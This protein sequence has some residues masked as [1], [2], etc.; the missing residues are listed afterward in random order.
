M[1]PLAGC[2]LVLCGLVALAILAADVPGT[3]AVRRQTRS[4]DCLKQFADG[5][6][7]TQIRCGY[8]PVPPGRSTAGRDCKH[9]SALLMA[10]LADGALP[11][12]RTCDAH[13]RPFEIVGSG[14]VDGAHSAIPGNCIARY[15][16]DWTSEIL[17]ASYGSDGKPNG[18]AGYYERGPLSADVVLRGQVA[19]GG[20]ISVWRAN[21]E[22]IAPNQLGSA[23]ANLLFGP[24]QD[25]RCRCE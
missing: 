3:M 18:E 11:C 21:T 8:Y 25:R 1:K 5:L 19:D 17:I 9:P 7:R 13:G 14:R 15:G 23:V 2:S 4:V 22:S 12:A 20:D 6:R 16:A 10:L 24:M